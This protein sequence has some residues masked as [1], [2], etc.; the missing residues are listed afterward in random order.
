MTIV[1]RFAS[2]S[3]NDR[4]EHH[5]LDRRSIIP[6]FVPV[7]FNL[8]IDLLVKQPPGQPKDKTAAAA[9][10]FEAHM[11]ALKKFAEQFPSAEAKGHSGQYV[12]VLVCPQF[13]ACMYARTTA[14]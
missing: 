10:A 6:M 2:G 11:T 14:C 4:T 1:V 5:L 12:R 9:A 13:C 7:K 8:A 3:V